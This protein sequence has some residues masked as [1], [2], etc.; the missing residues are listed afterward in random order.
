MNWL[1]LF[2]LLL[3]MTCPIKPTMHQR[4]VMFCRTYER[5][6]DCAAWVQDVLRDGYELANECHEVYPAGQDVPFM[7]CLEE[8]NF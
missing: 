3:V 8:F 2:I 5:H 7:I 1:T 6:I 4:M